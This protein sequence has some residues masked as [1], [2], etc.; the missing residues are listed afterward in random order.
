MSGEISFKMCYRIIYGKV[1]SLELGK[2]G[3]I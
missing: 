3:V 2:E 1:E